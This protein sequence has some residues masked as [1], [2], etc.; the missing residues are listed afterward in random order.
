MSYPSPFKATIEKLAENTVVALAGFKR[1]GKVNFGARMALF[2]YNNS[3][4]VWL[5][6]PYGEEV[7]RAV[8]QLTNNKNTP[9]SHMIIP[10]REH[11]MA[12][13][14]FKEKFPDLKILAGEGVECGFKPDYVISK[15]DAHTVLDKA[16]L[17]QLG[18]DAA[19]ADNF[20]FVFLPHH[21]NQEL[22]AYDVNLKIVYE[23][24]LLFNL[25]TDEKMQ[26][27][28][29]EVGFP[30]QENPFGGWSFV[31]RYMNPDSKVG[32]FMQTKIA[33]VPLSAEGLR[34][35]YG[36]D[37]DTMV[38]CHGNI[39]RNGAKEQFKKLFA[40]AFQ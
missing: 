5:A 34:N 30:E 3:V 28:S 8:E 6:F 21:A 25:R 12:A 7:E 31:G 17:T 11:T 22:V 16:R 24:D 14:S 33:D 15:S 18:I 26:Q 1:F 37:F 19:I 4:I 35:I 2:H 27:F 13:K 20:Q 39:L 36:W 10:D 29:P 32:R 9:I 40:C 38:M 23:A